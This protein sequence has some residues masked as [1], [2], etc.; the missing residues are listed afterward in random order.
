[1]VQDIVMEEME[2][3]LKGVTLGHDANYTLDY[4]KGYPPVINHTKEALQVLEASKNVSS[5]DTAEEIIPVMGGED[6]SYYLHEKPGAYFFTGAQ[7]EGHVYP[8]HH[9]K[10]D[11]DERALPIA[12]KMLYEVYMNYQKISH[13]S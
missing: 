5:V 6:F 13:S 4:F 3:I 11:I 12:A 8:H 2:R 9:P 7:L 1:H 10:F